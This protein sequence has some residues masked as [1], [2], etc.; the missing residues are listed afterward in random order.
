MTIIDEKLEVSEK[1]EKDIDLVE[2]EKID[3]DEDQDE[4]T[5][6]SQDDGPIDDEESKE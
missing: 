4:E 2:F 3:E 1:E 5:D 6:E